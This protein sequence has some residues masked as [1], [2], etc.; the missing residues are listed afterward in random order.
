MTGLLVCTLG[1]VVSSSGLQLSEA[2]KLTNPENLCN[3]L[4]TNT[5]VNV[6]SVGCAV[7]YSSY[8]TTICQFLL[9]KNVVHVYS[10]TIFSSATPTEHVSVTYVITVMNS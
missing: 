4:N 2:F 8:I 7:F 3:T 9:L 1:I 10:L 6:Q 5:H